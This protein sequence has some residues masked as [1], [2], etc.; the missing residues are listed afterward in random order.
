[1]GLPLQYLYLILYGSGRQSAL[2]V[3]TLLNIIAAR[4]GDMSS[5]TRGA[6]VVAVIGRCVDKPSV[7]LCYP[8]C[9]R[10]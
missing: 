1:M 3:E 10:V 6:L 7:F 5:V 8:A 9:L 2:T 4:G